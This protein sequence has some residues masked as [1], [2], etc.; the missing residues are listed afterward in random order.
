VILRAAW[1]VARHEVAVW[2]R[3]PAAMCAA[4][5]PALGLGALVYVLTVTIGM[6]PVA[7]VQEG[8]GPTADQMAHLFEADTEAYLLS[9]MDRDE[10]ARAL[11]H[12][13]VAAV[14]VIPV[15]FEERV[16][17]ASAHVELFLNN[18]VDVDLA[19]DIRRAISRS[20]AEL[21]APQLGFVGERR[22]GRATLPNPFRVAIAE[23]LL[24][25]T[26]TSF[27]SYQMVPILVLIVLSVGVLGTAMMVA[28][29][30]ERRTAKILFL[31]PAGGPAIVMGKLLGGL[32]TTAL[33]LAPLLA[34]AL[35]M[36]A[37]SIPEGHCPALAL[38]LVLL[39]VMSVGMGVLLG[40]LVRRVRLTAMVGL[41]ASAYLFF[42]GGGFT[43]T[44]FLPRWLE[45]A[46]RLVPTSYAIRALRQALFY[47]D[48]VGFQR[49]AAVLA[50]AALL[51]A[52][53]AVLALLRA[54]KTA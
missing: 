31:S 38:I 37:L 54:W 30:F 48:L 24:R 13:R 9:R 10:A 23:E 3:S 52:A 40:L 15:D 27:A 34:A 36:G 5:L 26:D 25:E 51:F 42:L 43:T 49:D 53:C 41:N 7:L 29:D 11:W 4:L 22:T 14:V 35:G 18:V 46:S 50:G 20:L 47:P 19:D 2:I 21:D 45:T 32:L 6:Q 28:R 12:Q 39:V 33:L 17:S 44:A 8:H 1:G 16:A